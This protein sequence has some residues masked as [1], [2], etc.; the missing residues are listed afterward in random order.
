MQTKKRGIALLTAMAMIIS[1]FPISSF[2]SE[3]GSDAVKYEIKKPVVGVMNKIN[4]ENDQFRR[5]YLRK[6]DDNFNLVYKFTRT[7]E[8]N[9][10][11]ADSTLSY[12]TSMMHK[13]NGDFW[14][15][16]YD[17]NYQKEVKKT[18]SGGTYSVYEPTYGN[19]G[20]ANLFSSGQVY[21]DFSAN[22]TADY[23]RNYK[24][25]GNKIL[26]RASATIDHKNQYGVNGLMH[27][28]SAWDAPDDS[29]VYLHET[30]KLKINNFL[31]FQLYFTGLGCKCGSSKV[32]NV[33]IGLIDKVN[34]K[35]TSIT[36]SRTLGGEAETNGFKANETGYINLNFDE[37]I[38]FAN[39]EV[40]LESIMLNLIIKGIESNVQI[41]TEEIKGRLVEV[42]G[43]RMS[44]RFNV[45]ENLSDKPINVY[46]SGISNNQDWVNNIGG[47]N[48]FPLV[49]L[50][51][52]GTNITMTGSLAQVEELTK[53]SSIITDMSGN[54]VNWQQSNKEM[55]TKCFLDNVAPRIMSVDISGARISAESNQSS[56]AEDWPED[57]DR[58]AVF[59]GIGDIL[60]FSAKFSEQ[61]SI[62]EGVDKVTAFL[63]AQEGG[64]PVKLK[65]ASLEE[66][67]D[68]VNGIKVS[69]IIFEPLEITENM[70]LNGD[71]S[72]LKITE[73][74]F[75]NDTA[76]YR[77]NVISSST[78]DIPAASQQ[79][80]LDT[81][82]PEVKTAVSENDGKYTPVFYDNQN[83]KEFYFPI[84]INDVDNISSNNEYASGTNGMTGSFAWLDEDADATF[85]FEYYVSA[86]NEK[87]SD[88]Q[89]ITGVT[90]NEAD[91]LSTL[92]FNQVEGGN[93]IHI[94]LLDGVKY[95][96]VDSEIVVLPGDYAQN[97]GRNSFVMDYSADLV[98]PE[99]IYGGYRQD[100]NSLNDEGTISVSAIMKDSSGT[101]PNDVEYQWVEKDE[102][103][104]EGWEN[105]TGEMENGSTSESLKIK[106][107]SDEFGGG[108]I[109]ALDLIIRT[110]DKKGNMSENLR[111]P[112]IIDFTKSN[113]NIEIKNGLD[114]PSK[115]I[116][117]GM[118][119][120]PYS[121]DS[122]S[123]NGLPATSVIMIK[124]PEKEEEYFVTAISSMD[125]YLLDTKD[126]RN[127]LFYALR[128]LEED[129]GFPRTDPVVSSYSKWYK[130]DVTFGDNGS[131]LLDSE[132]L[133]NDDLYF[134]GSMLNPLPNYSYN[135]RNSTYY[136][137]IDVTFITAYGYTPQL[138]NVWGYKDKEQLPINVD[139]NEHG[140]GNS[141]AFY[142][143]EADG[144]YLADY[145]MYGPH[146]EESF[147]YKGTYP[148]GEPT[149]PSGIEGQGY[150]IVDV[151]FPITRIEGN[152]NVQ[153]FNVSLAPSGRDFTK[154]TMDV[155]FGKT[156]Q[157]DGTEGLLW[158]DEDYV[159]GGAAKYMKNLDGARILFTLCNPEVPSWGVKE[160]DF[161]SDETYV[162]LYYTEHGVSNS[163]SFNNGLTFSDGGRYKNINELTPLIKS[164]PVATGNEQVFVIS[165]GI[166]DSTGFYALEV[167]LKS[168]NS[169]DVEKIYFSDMFVNG[170]TIEDEGLNH[171]SIGIKDEKGEYAYNNRIYSDTYSILIGSA[172]NSDGYEGIRDILID[173]KVEG[174]LPGS[175]LWYHDY[176]DDIIKE[177]N[178]SNHS[179]LSKG[180]I[181]IWNA[182]S[183]VDGNAPEYAKWQ[184]MR[185]YG[186]DINLNI[187]DSEEELNE[188]SYMNGEISCLPIINNKVNTI[189]YQL[190]LSNGELTSVRQFNIT[191]A[192]SRPEFELV[193]DSSKEGGWVSSVTVSAENVIAINGARTFNCSFSEEKIEE[194]MEPVTISR[195]DKYYFYVSDMAGNVEIKKLEIDWIDNEEP[196]L[197]SEKISSDPDNEFHVK[198]KIEDDHD[199]T[200]GK[201]YLSFDENYSAVLNSNSGEPGLV[202][203][204]VPLSDNGTGQWIAASPEDARAG[205]YKTDTVL[206]EDKLNNTFKKTVEIWGA[207]KYDDSYGAADNYSARLT[208]SGSDQAGNMS[209]VYKNESY[210]DG[211]TGESYEYFGDPVEGTY[212]DFSAKNI[213]PEFDGA[214]LTSDDKVRLSFTAPVLVTVPDNSNP[215]FSADT[216]SAA[217]Y[218]D[219]ECSI[220]YMDLFG[221]NSIESVN[222]TAFGDFNT[223]I[224][225]SDTQPTQNDV[226][227]AVE[228]PGDSTAVITGFNGTIA[229][230]Q[231]N[232]SLEGTIE[233]G[234]KSAI[235]TMTDNGSMILTI[236]NKGKTKDRSMIISNID[237]VIESVE[238]YIYYTGG[239]PMGDEAFTTDIVVAGIYCN[240]LLTG[241]NGPLTYTFTDGA[242]A[243]DSYTFEYEDL[244]KN[245]GSITVNLDYDVV[246]MEK[247]EAPP[248]YNVV[249]Y[250]KLDY[251]N[252]QRDS[253]NSS[254]SIEK[255]IESLPA[256]QG[257]MMIFNVADSSKVKM[258][259]KE[260]S[261]VPAYDD[262]SDT[263]TGV[264]VNDRAVMIDE[265]AE[266]I[267]Y[268]VD[269]KGNVTSLPLMNFDK[270]DNVRPSAEVEYV[271]ETFF[272][273][274]GY[275]IPDNDEEIIATNVT[276]V[277]KDTS[278]GNYDGKYYHKYKD[279][280]EFLFYYKDQVGNINSTEA[281]VDW[282]DVSPPQ[283]LSVKWTPV[284]EGQ[285]K[286]DAIYPP[287]ELHTNKDINAQ[288]KFNKT[289]QDVKAYYKG[290]TNEVE[291][292]K[293]EISFIQSGA[294]VT[295]H[296]NA[297]IDLY[298]KSY[299]GKDALFNIGDVVCID[300]KEFNV[301]NSFVLADDKQSIRYTF[302]TDKDVFMAENSSGNTV[303]FG[304]EFTYTFTAN[305]SYD[306]HFTDEAGNSVVHTVKVDQIDKENMKVYFNTTAS[307]DGAVD[308]AG[309]LE[310]G[311]TGSIEF[312]VKLSK[313]GKVKFN[314]GSA[315]D[316]EKNKW[317]KFEFTPSEDT[318]F[319]VVEA[320]DGVRGT[321]I[322][323][324]LNVLLP[325]RVPPTILF[326][327]PV[328]SVREG[329]IAED[330]LSKL[331]S[332]VVVSDNKD[333]AVTDFVISIADW[334]DISINISDSMSPGKYKVTYE[335]ADTSGNKTSSYR[336]LRVYGKDS[337]NLL[338]NGEGA[339]SEGTMVL[340]TGDI[341]LTIENLPVYGINEEP[342]TV[343][344]KEGLKTPGQ[345]KTRAV[346]AETDSF[347]LPGTGFY[348]IYVRA[349]DRKDYITYVYIQK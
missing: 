124:N 217:I 262:V 96:M 97:K 170:F 231:G 248:E 197:K 14:K 238:P 269:E 63:N 71:I 29:A 72:P 120:Q 45:P 261:F 143:D 151:T 78:S 185:T 280:E 36:A 320:V 191:T 240:E 285:G 112:C 128:V 305:G 211:E 91:S 338:I 225:Y 299:N 268:L 349:Q 252:Q 54:P 180:G 251:M 127:D 291:N 235:I 255:A 87:P 209:P 62:P 189:C 165:D 188:S 270:V 279:N 25:H 75:P 31:G 130:A 182:G 277:E 90:S 314:G 60:T 296:E 272:S 59:A 214:S 220:S 203:V 18:Y 16:Y 304:K 73:V 283:V 1:M 156:I 53:T 144:I 129:S 74:E 319:Y 155:E 247:D 310:L 329:S 85:N 278:L 213:K 93:Y 15:A 142:L 164:K 5:T 81:Q 250:S 195:N 316:T 348:T 33:S 266:F 210:T 176:H 105:F 158:R 139:F 122:T 154:K 297:D 344:W 294:V 322:Y 56:Q 267:I 11:G 317:L 226:T 109:E 346:K 234:G 7:S 174:E 332:G 172:P 326:A 57:I 335:V 6:V 276:G 254:E 204:E 110:A 207:F 192:D 301:A 38:R 32:S 341:T 259:L 159:L 80:Y 205:I 345:M 184:T 26:D 148:G 2:A 293:V 102:E 40:P 83:K 76:D 116:E 70:V 228:I 44:F 330:I 302:T 340:N 324:Y 216:D 121:G 41:N 200:D 224:K 111:I 162:A 245:H 61:L 24:R 298:F 246:V 179:D 67:D 260:Q 292:S 321:K 265:N 137:K 264:T 244:A 52:N 30:S 300:R 223:Y 132:E 303:D 275:L 131:Y 115:T 229:G 86:S 239:K 19:E 313:N 163:G 282:L 327:S 219:G 20:V 323:N 12:N 198:V 108:E 237:R 311:S 140:C 325:D 138:R 21:M 183:M 337:L 46:V 215:Q 312:Y 257:Y 9:I 146:P 13:E 339:E 82:L 51:K 106:I 92:S 117:I 28:V 190:C 66:I 153:E 175:R 152:I 196:N 37:P 161:D 309:K 242:K 167:S 181:R 103:P 336:I 17:W 48:K 286:E 208:F 47:A 95:N 119:L 8:N 101:N 274:V 253:L 88:S 171:Y 233:E 258:I 168:L 343:F 89:Y 263:I 243:G 315:V 58:S 34:P 177:I 27:L 230:A 222:V 55:S 107:E 3:N 281:P 206:S 22:L 307:D 136:G 306:M 141:T 126:G 160:I 169:N 42:T 118:D 331:K 104:S 147:Y 218:S 288:I 295:Y 342:S 328:V 123:L 241:T 194:N 69:K 39:D 199:L 271:A 227:V 334:Q 64:I 193:T 77:K 84:S 212:I 10:K 287:P 43:K 50:G 150:E 149:T 23:H 318:A 68:G 166:T 221:N 79:Q 202:S 284:G 201:L 249:L 308:N 4:S 114:I 99:I 133:N 289:V 236:E 98:G 145:I 157:S 186:R 232:T 113:P 94:K 135:G 65:G 333:G 134:L 49:L 178:L 173:A 347:T 187:V 256:A 273:T 290:T 100:F 125:D 35:V